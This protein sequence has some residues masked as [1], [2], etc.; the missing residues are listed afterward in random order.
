MVLEHDTYDMPQ[1]ISISYLNSNADDDKFGESRS[2]NEKAPLSAGSHRH[3][4][5]EEK[6]AVSFAA[7]LTTRRQ[8]KHVGPDFQERA[9]SR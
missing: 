3:V 9:R 7:V 2:Y 6:C 4:C 5:A 1:H 8:K